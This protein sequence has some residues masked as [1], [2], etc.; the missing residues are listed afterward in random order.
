MNALLISVTM[1]VLVIFYL[2]LSI[3]WEHVRRPQCF[4]LGCA[5]IIL[6]I[7]FVGFFSLFTGRWAMVLTVV[8]SM[9]L[10]I[11]A[12]GC[13]VFTCYQAKLP[14]KIPGLE[15]EDDSASSSED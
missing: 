8:F 6:N 3:R 4:L 15:S 10:T 2:V 12:F 7:L 5:A 11:V 1:V 13:A 9:I 14:V